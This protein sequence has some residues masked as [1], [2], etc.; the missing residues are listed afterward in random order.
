MYLLF[1]FTIHCLHLLIKYE[2]FQYNFSLHSAFVLV[3]ANVHAIIYYY[4]R[5]QKKV[6]KTILC[7]VHF[8]GQLVK[9]KDFCITFL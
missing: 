6:K 1:T 3:Y 4:K 2:F 7:I 5:Q 8:A 9:L